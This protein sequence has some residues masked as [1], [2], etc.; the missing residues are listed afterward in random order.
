MGRGRMNHHIGVQKVDNF[1]KNN[2]MGVCQCAKFV[3]AD[4]LH[5]LQRQNSKVTK[6]QGICMHGHS[7]MLVT[8]SCHERGQAPNSQIV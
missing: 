2:F 7:S 3:Y 8:A 5:I 6:I 4:R 1:L